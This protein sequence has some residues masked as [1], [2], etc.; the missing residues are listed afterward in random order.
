MKMIQNPD[1]FRKTIIE[2]LN[3]YIQNSKKANNL[4]KSIY[5]FSIKQAKIK[6]IVRKWNNIH[7]INIY[8]YKYYNILMNINPDNYIQ[9]S[10]LLNKIQNDEIDVKEVAFMSHQQL[11]PKLWEEIIQKKIKID[12]NMYET[13]MSSSTDEFKCYKCKRRKCTYYQMQ[14]RSADEP[15][16]TFVTCLNCGAN[17]KC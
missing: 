1:L 16:T 15:M 8:K 4:E 2:N 9:N 6:E 7:F 13:N 11:F 14:T 10:Y 5:N 3:K 12:E 17:W